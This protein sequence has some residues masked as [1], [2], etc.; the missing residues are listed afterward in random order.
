MLFVPRLHTAG[1]WLLP[2]SEVPKRGTTEI[3]RWNDKV[4]DEKASWCAHEVLQSPQRG[5]K[6]K[7]TQRLWVQIHQTFA[8]YLPGCITLLM[9][10]CGLSLLTANGRR[11][12][13]DRLSQ[14]VFVL[15]DDTDIARLVQHHLEA[16]GFS[17]RL[18]H[19]ATNVISD[20]ERQPPALFLLD[21]MV[22]GGDGLDV[23]RRLRT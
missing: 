21:I 3:C 12:R 6:R 11:V 2:S 15:E 7:L 8:I 5:V 17:A 10:P 18:F 22:P 20:A 16:A 19:T 4:A 14:T 9:V 23:C 1:H 13:A